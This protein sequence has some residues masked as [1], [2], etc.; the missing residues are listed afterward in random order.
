MQIRGLKYT[1]FCTH[2]P[3]PATEGGR[4]PPLA[5]FGGDRGLAEA[6]GGLLPSHPFPFLFCFVFCFFLK[7]IYLVFNKF[8]FFY[9]DGHVSPSYR[10]DVMLTWHLTKSIKFFNRI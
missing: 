5:T 4:V 3:H 8:I 10:I 9:S 7:Y 6:G 1:I 2:Q